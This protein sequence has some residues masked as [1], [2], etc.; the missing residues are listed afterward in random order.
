MRK[1]RETPEFYFEELDKE[2]KPGEHGEIY[3]ALK[4]TND[5]DNAGR[6]GLICSALSLFL[7]VVPFVYKSKVNWQ[8]AGILAF[9]TLLLA[10]IS[11]WGQRNDLKTRIG[12]KISTLEGMFG[13]LLSMMASS[14]AIM[15]VSSLI[16]S[17]IC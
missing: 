7:T 9:T 16:F 10:I 12:Q 4:A 15:T 5:A 3:S 17:R 11:R 8:R 6:I 14:A 1:V 2:Q 13:L